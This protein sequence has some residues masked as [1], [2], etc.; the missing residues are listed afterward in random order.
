MNSKTEIK[1][2]NNTDIKNEDTNKQSKQ[3]NKN[4]IVVTGDSDQKKDSVS[5]KKLQLNIFLVKRVIRL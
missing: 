4:K 1:K 3:R 2:V 5:P